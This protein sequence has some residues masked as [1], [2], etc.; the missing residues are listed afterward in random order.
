MLR[1]TYELIFK[2]KGYQVLNSANN[3]E[4]AIQLYEA[5]P[6]KPDI[7]LMDHRMPIKTGLETAKEILK[8]NNNAKIIFTSADYSIKDKAL[9]IG[10]SDFVEK[11]FVY[12]ELIDKIE[13]ILNSHKICC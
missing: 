5:F 3:G 10:V 8:I 11:P 9:S 13:I 4:R 2:L 12:E 7:I 6:K 1:R